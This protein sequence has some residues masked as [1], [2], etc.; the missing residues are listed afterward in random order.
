MDVIAHPASQDLYRDVSLVKLW[1]KK[2]DGARCCECVQAAVLSN[3][4]GNDISMF[5]KSSIDSCIP[6]REG[7]VCVCVGGG[8]GGGGQGTCSST[9]TQKGIFKLN[10]Q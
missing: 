1:V 6:L 3:Q 7:C 9:N 5:P 4:W 2:N 10:M 8:G